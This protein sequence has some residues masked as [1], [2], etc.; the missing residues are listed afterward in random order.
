M[1]RTF[2]R[3]LRSLLASGCFGHFSVS[4]SLGGAGNCNLGNRFCLGGA[5]GA[6]REKIHP[7]PYMRRACQSRVFRSN[8]FQLQAKSPHVGLPNKRTAFSQTQPHPSRTWHYQNPRRQDNEHTPPSQENTTTI[9][10]KLLSRSLARK[11]A[12]PIDPSQVVTASLCK[13]GRPNVSQESQCYHKRLLRAQCIISRIYP[14]MIVTDKPCTKNRQL[15]QKGCDQSLAHQEQISEHIQ[16]MLLPNACAR[17]GSSPI[18]LF[19][20][21]A[22][23]PRFSSRP[24][25]PKT[26]H[27]L[28]HPKQHILGRLLLP[29]PLC[30]KG[31]WT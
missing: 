2:I 14:S 16:I 20:K 19:P 12:S 25:T 27:P 3:Y 6:L 15:S 17:K 28:H 29:N 18:P 23:Q 9:Q 7:S 11:T 10:D 31:R 13:K 22:I 24:C 5:G 30:A 4:S 1:L 8:L 26:A 21:R